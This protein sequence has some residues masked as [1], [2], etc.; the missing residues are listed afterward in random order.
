MLSYLPNSKSALPKCRFPTLFEWN[1]HKS[2]Y[3]WITC[4]N[5]KYSYIPFFRNTF[6]LLYIYAQLHKRTLKLLIYLLQWKLYHWWTIFLDDTL[7]I[8]VMTILIFRNKIHLSHFQNNVRNLL[9]STYSMKTFF[10]ISA[11]GFQRILFKNATIFVD[12]YIRSINTR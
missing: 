4:Y 11:F 10:F 12:T 8:I 2:V 7:V 1:A 3:I 6:V 9:C 5:D